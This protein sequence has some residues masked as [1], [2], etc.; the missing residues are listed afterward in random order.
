M[1][2]KQLKHTHVEK[3]ILDGGIG[4]SCNEVLVEAWELAIHE[5]VEVSFTMNKME[6]TIKPV[7]D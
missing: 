3:I 2:H 6:I 1:F 4:F 7:E 5:N